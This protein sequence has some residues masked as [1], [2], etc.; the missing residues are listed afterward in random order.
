[1]ARI[2]TGPLV[3]SVMLA[4]TVVQM[5]LDAFF[6]GGLVRMRIAAAR[7]EAVHLADMFSG[8]STFG[9]ML[10]L[11]FVIG[12]P[13]LAASVLMLMASV[14]HQPALT[15]V[16]QA[17]NNLYV[18]ALVIATPFGLAFADY[19]VVDRGEGPFEAIRSAFAA[20]AGDRG[21]VFGA[22]LVTGLVAFAGFFAC[23]LGVIAS[24]PY[25]LVCVA[26]LYTRLTNTAAPR[27]DT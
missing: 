18:L 25:A 1:M 11:R 27:L 22:I 2:M 15:Q 23:C 19:F 3:S 6:H 5:F 20:P 7:G 17:L 8:A 14:L 21:S 10:G 12:A 26:V 4:Y 9:S 13:S 16:S 24:V